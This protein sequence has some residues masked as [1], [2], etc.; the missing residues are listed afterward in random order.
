[1]RKS[2]KYY[3]FCVL[4]SL[5]ING[6]AQ[7]QEVDGI[8][9]DLD[10]RNRINRVKITNLTTGLSL[11]NST[12]GEFKIPAKSGDKVTAYAEGYYQDT[13]VYK[14]QSA[15]VFY[16]KRM[17]IPLQEV[18]VKDS[19][20]SARKRYEETKRQFN[21]LTRIGNN[22][23]LLSVGSSGA[24]LSIDAIWSAFSKEGKNARRLMD[25]MERDYINNFI[26]EKFNRRLVSKVTGLTGDQLEVF[27][28]KYRPSYYF[29]YG[30]SEYDLV[31]YI[32]T[33]YSKFQKYPFLED[34]SHLKPIELK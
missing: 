27:M 20:E 33:A 3:F 4:F 22:K 30:A 24:G 34:V 6:F 25:I 11:F 26:D 9:A 10:T 18:L 5:G 13:L 1:M 8:V 15:L 19:L 29:V 12:K 2:L 21:S 28:I 23:D 16:L 17:A 7:E 14:G 31:S 32:Q